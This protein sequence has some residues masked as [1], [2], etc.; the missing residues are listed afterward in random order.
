M[1]WISLGLTVRPRDKYWRA[2]N[3]DP[4]L[5][6]QSANQEQPPEQQPPEQQPQKQQPQEQQPQE[7]AG[8]NLFPSEI[9][10][11][12]L[13]VHWT[14]RMLRTRYNTSPGCLPGYQSQK[15]DRPNEPAN[16]LP[17]DS[18]QPSRYYW[19]ERTESKI[20]SESAQQKGFQLQECEPDA[21]E[22]GLYEAWFKY[23]GQLYDGKKHKTQKRD[24]EWLNVLSGFTEKEDVKVPKRDVRDETM[25]EWF[26]DL[27]KD[28][29]SFG[30]DD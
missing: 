9:H 13:E 11:V 14:V 20:S 2:F 30:E 22:R 3:R 1:K 15:R 5:N 27:R 10:D 6:D 21:E 24:H 18:R 26:L 8:R 17:A 29:S 19:S 23:D 25:R 7:E 16:G 12:S 4:L 28:I